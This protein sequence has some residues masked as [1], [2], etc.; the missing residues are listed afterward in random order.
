MTDLD[1]NSAPAGDGVSANAGASRGDTG[2]FWSNRLFA[3]LAV[4]ALVVP[5]VAVGIIMLYGPEMERQAYADLQVIADLKAEQVELWL[6]ERQRDAE[7]IA[8]TQAFIGRVADTPASRDPY[9]QQLIH[10]RLEAVQNAYGYE[11]VQLLNTEGRAFLAGEGQP[12]LPPATRALLPAALQVRQIRNSDLFLDEQGIPRLDIVVPL[13]SQTTR[14]VAAFVVLRADLRQ[15]LLP[16]VSKWPVNSRSA[17]TLLVRQEDGVIVHLTPWRHTA[18]TLPPA[19]GSPQNT[20]A[21]L[22]TRDGHGGITQGIDYRGE[23]VLAAFRPVTGTGWHLI[24]KIDREEVLANLWI[25]VFWVGAVMLLSVIAVG[26]AV[27]QIWRQQRHAHRLE[28]LVRTAE[29]DKL[30]K[31]FYELPFIGMAITSPDN[32]RWL[33]YNDRL[34]EILG[35]SHDEL[36]ARNWVEMTH[37]DDVGKDIAAF[38]RIMRG[39]SDSYVRNKRYIRKDGSIVL[40]NVSVKCVRTDEGKVDY[41][42]AMIGDITEQEN[43]KLEALAAQNQLR[44]TLDAIPDLLLEL[45][46]DGCCHSYHSARTSLPAVP[47]EILLGSRIAD[48]LPPEAVKVILSALAEAQEKGLSAGRQLELGPPQSRL[49]LELS[50]SRKQVD[51]AQDARFIV[52][53][54]D[55][56]ERKAAEQHIL[57]LAHYDSLT[58]LPNRALLADRMR[59]AIRRAQRQATRLAVLYV[60]LDRFKSINDSLGHDVGDQLL[61]VAAQRMQDCVRGIDTVSRVGGD[62]FVIL[63]SEI[64]SAENAGRVA[65]KLIRALSQ[66]YSVAGHEL[67]VTA[68]VGICIC[69]DSGTQSSVLLRNADASMYSAKQSGRNRYQFYSDA[70]TEQAMARLS[71]EHDL[72]GA[73][74]RGEFF[75]EYQPQIDLA[76]H[77]IIGVEVL[78]RWQ[79]ATLGLIPPAQFIPIA[80]DSG[81]VLAI[82]EWVLGQACRQ[83]RAWH[84]RGVLHGRISVNISAV[85]IR[86]SDFVDIVKRAVE[87]SRLPPDSLELELTESTVMQD[88]D[89]NVQKLR[90]LETMGVKV[91]ID[92][93]GTGYSSLSYLRQFT[94]NRLKIDQSLV[95]D[96]P[97]NLDAEAIATAIVA[98]GISLGLRI[99]AEGV[100]TEAQADFLQGVLCREGQGYLYARPMRVAQF[101]EWVVA[102]KRHIADRPPPPG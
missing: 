42:V 50:V 75:L 12:D 35:Y 11:S 55:I 26:A 59:L 63:L 53:A 76:T 16:L 74:Q 77:R 64:G 22:A 40:A 81:L 52:L 90:E 54:R 102:W 80:E 60:D 97:G 56:T 25:L 10:N 57:N 8:A 4:L 89:S 49:W 62:E 84:E 83:A 24:S 41:F 7:T 2:R 5:V 36:S 58:G 100:E 87:A 43:R 66:P 94:V 47:V 68:S 20:L 95:R 46:L 82:G 85:Q 39:E 34:C 6:T 79:H 71:L 93:F 65:E 30:L 91:A 3:M 70:M 17:E 37:P 38:E 67:E 86:Q 28:L 96:V 21:A 45:D 61:K 101:E 48:T 31:Y 69:P 98:M 14:Q 9:L 29:Q 73:L 33:R 23:P 32:K 72:R 99:I 27:W 51:P 18:H 1:R 13:V 92:D 88:I 44:A 15:F 19:S 78:V